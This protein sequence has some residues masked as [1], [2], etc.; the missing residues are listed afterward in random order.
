MSS[1][2]TL[3]AILSGL[4]TVFGG[5]GL[6]GAANWLRRTWRRDDRLDLS[7]D[8]VLGNKEKGMLGLVYRVQRVERKLGIDSD[9]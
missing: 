6:I 5:A 2:L 1:F 3:V 9:P 8:W 4:A 7:A